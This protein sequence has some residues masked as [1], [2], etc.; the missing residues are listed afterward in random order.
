M[1]RITNVQ[2]ERTIETT[3]VIPSLYPCKQKG[4]LGY[5][6]L[7]FV[8]YASTIQQCDIQMGAAKFEIVDIFQHHRN[9]KP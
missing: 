2:K 1:N 3:S 9:K 8:Q 5:K 6:I 7:I 4:Y